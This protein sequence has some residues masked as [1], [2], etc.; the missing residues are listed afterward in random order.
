MLNH[1][2]VGISQ[3]VILSSGL[4]INSVRYAMCSLENRGGNDLHKCYQVLPQTRRGGKLDW[5]GSLSLTPLMYTLSEMN[6]AHSTPWTIFQ[7]S[8]AIDMPY[9]VLNQEMTDQVYN[10]SARYSLLGHE[11]RSLVKSLSVTYV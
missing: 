2:E 5:T 9:F 11:E 10:L 8:D 4:D 7:H 3:R 1:M 6:A